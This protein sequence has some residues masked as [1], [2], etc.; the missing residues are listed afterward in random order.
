MG[1]RGTEASMRSSLKLDIKQGGLLGGEAGCIER[2]HA[3]KPAGHQV[4]GCSGASGRPCE[5]FA[6]AAREESLMCSRRY[7]PF[8]S[9]ERPRP[10]RVLQIVSA[11][12][13][14]GSHPAQR[15]RESQGRP[16]S[17]QTCMRVCACACTC[18]APG[19]GTVHSKAGK[20][21]RRHSSKEHPKAS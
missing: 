15:P 7:S 20:G 3:T 14:S 12:R 8:H 2:E 4:T 16:G 18:I 9:H 21:A 10:R 6:G 5:V 11:L 17:I 1:G 19:M 13:R